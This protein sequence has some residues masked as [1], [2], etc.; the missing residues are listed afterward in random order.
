MTRRILLALLTL[1]IALV[2]GAGTLLA[3][4]A[5]GHDRASFTEELSD[6]TRAYAANYQDAL[7]TY[8]GSMHVNGLTVDG[9]NNDVRQAG[10]GLLVMR[11]DSAIYDVQMPYYDN[12]LTV[13][14]SHWTSLIHAA[15]GEGPPASKAHVI[16]ETSGSYMVAAF[17][18]YQNGD[19]ASGNVPIGTLLLARSL[20]PLNDEIGTLWLIL[21]AISVAAILAAALIAVWLARWVS[22]P[23]A[24]LDTAALR[25]ADGDLSIRAKDDY[26]PPELRRMSR[27]FNTMAGRLETLVHGSRAALADVSHQLRTPLAALRLRLDFLAADVAESDPE[28]ASELAGAQEEVARLSRLVDGLLAVARAENVTPQPRAID[29]AA[30]AEERV[31]AWSPVAD[32][33]GITLTAARETTTSSHGWGPVVGWIGDGHLEQILDNVI[34]NALDAIGE[35]IGGAAGRVTVTAGPSEGGVLV[36]VSDNGPGMGPE[37]R[38]RA[39]LRFTSSSAGAGNGIGGTGIGLAI[40]HRLVT[41]NGGTAKLADTPGGGL[42]VLLEFPAASSGS[43]AGADSGIGAGVAIGTAA[44]AAVGNPKFS[45]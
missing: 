35:Q 39:F 6:T 43:S 27:T 42:T 26:G 18:I 38:E 19:L 1:I 29:V 45:R 5:A 34:A 37:D 2:G 10:D 28:M 9:V 3:I 40:V 21:G 32:D 41:S 36:T 24:A 7:V 17:P 16:A 15:E 22:K 30:V 33:R 20:A 11:G 12:A 13:P 23:L 14:T 31:V 25:L 4:D 44:G 8:G